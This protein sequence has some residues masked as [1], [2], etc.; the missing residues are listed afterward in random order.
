MEH[1]DS[2]KLNVLEECLLEDAAHEGYLHAGEAESRR[3]AK[4]A[5]FKRSRVLADA[6]PVFQNAAPGSLTVLEMPCGSGAHTEWL[7]QTF[8]SIRKIVAVDFSASLLKDAR[9]RCAGLGDRVEFFL[10]DGTR[11]ADYPGFANR[12]GSF[13]VCI[14]IMFFEH[15]P[16][17]EARISAAK[18]ALRCLKPGGTLFSSECSSALLQFIPES[19]S[20]ARYYREYCRLQNEDLSGDADMGIRMATVFEEAGFVVSEEP[21]VVAFCRRR[22]IRNET[23]QNGLEELRLWAIDALFSCKDRLL[24]LGRVSQEQVDQVRNYLEGEVIQ[25]GLYGLINTIAS[26]PQME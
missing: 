13:D 5:E 9:K 3:L 4:Q 26:C 25:E 21:T 18:A 15:L 23:A 24:Q 17:R 6:L 16:G 2:P 11:L 10:A 8:P 22:G 19:P 1:L 12:L 20:F 7:A 14:S